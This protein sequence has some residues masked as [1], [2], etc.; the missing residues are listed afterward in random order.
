MSIQASGRA[1]PAPG[2]WSGDGKTIVYVEQSSDSNGNTLRA[3]GPD[4]KPFIV[5]ERCAGQAA[6]SH[7]GRWVAFDEQSGSIVVT[8]FPSAQGR[9]QVTAN[10]AV[11]PAWGPADD[12]VLFMGA[13]GM[14]HSTSIRIAGGAVG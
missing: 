1:S 6:M 12:S 9:W 7:D 8:S 2:D 14:L 11:S 5:V 3:V 13:D 10:G 4:R